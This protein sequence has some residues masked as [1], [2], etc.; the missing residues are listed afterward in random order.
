M[1]TIL[2]TSHLI[3]LYYIDYSVY[4]E[5]VIYNLKMQKFASFLLL[6]S[7]IAKILSSKTV[8]MFITKITIVKVICYYL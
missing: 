8:R 2:I 1:K 7:F 4:L 6:F 3:F 5:N